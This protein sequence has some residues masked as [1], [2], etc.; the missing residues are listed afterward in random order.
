[1][2]P[3]KGRSNEREAALYG[4]AYSRFGVRIYRIKKRAGLTSRTRNREAKT[5]P[6]RTGS[7]G[8]TEKDFD[9]LLILLILLILSKSLSFLAAALTG[10]TFGQD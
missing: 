4:K 2:S 6:G 8:L 7:T 5:W 10:N 1:M 9:W 3:G